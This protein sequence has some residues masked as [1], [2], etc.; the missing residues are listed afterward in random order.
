MNQYLADI[1]IQPE[2]LRGALKKLDLSPIKP[3]REMLDGGKI[4]RIVLTGM[5]ASLTG[6]YP[7]WIHL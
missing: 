5:G 7:A 2:S 6:L 4:D 3:I 1:L